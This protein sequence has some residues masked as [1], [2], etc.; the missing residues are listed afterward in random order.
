MHGAHSTHQIHGFIGFLMLY[1]L[2]FVLLNC[3][4]RASQIQFTDAGRVDT[5]ATLWW[6]Q[7]SKNNVALRKYTIVSMSLIELWA[8]RQST[9]LNVDGKRVP[10][11][12]KAKSIACFQTIYLKDIAPKYIAFNLKIQ[13]SFHLHFLAF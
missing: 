6:C 4:L 9:Q 10:E 2:H 11:L 12:T 3:G 5:N 8:L 7:A 13:S 1:K